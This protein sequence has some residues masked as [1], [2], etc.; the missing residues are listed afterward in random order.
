MKTGVFIYN[1]ARRDAQE[2]Q[3]FKEALLQVSLAEDLGYQE[4]WFAEH[5]HSDYSLLPSPNLL[6][7]AASQRTSRIRLGNLVN[8]L[9]FHDPVRL[10]E[11]IATLDNLTE[12]RLNVGIGRGIRRPEFAAYGLDRPGAEDRFAEALNVM[13]R[14]WTEERFSHEGKFWKYKDVSI[15]PRVFQ[16][17]FPPLT[18]P[19]VSTESIATV[20]SN[21]WQIAIGRQTVPEAKTMAA[22]YRAER[23]A[24][25]LPAGGGGVLLHRFIYIAETDEQ[26]MAEGVPA[27]LDYWHLAAYNRLATSPIGLSDLPPMTIRGGYGGDG[28]TLAELIKGGCVLIGG[29][30]TVTNSLRRI[31]SEIGPTSLVGSFAFGSLSHEQVCRSMTLFAKC[32]A[33]IEVGSLAMA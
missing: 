10:A 33:T 9:P 18:Y 4:A 15:R 6:I 30:E 24:A 20:A 29:P 26:A 16:E 13:I 2:H 7:A 19:S 31:A 14:G 3:L 22:T 1:Q 12:G 17:P 25:G 28:V 27:L 21:G 32:T 8:I 5:H 11:E 23:A